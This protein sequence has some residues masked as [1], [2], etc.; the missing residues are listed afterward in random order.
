MQSVKQNLKELK[1]IPYRGKSRQ[2]KKKKQFKPPNIRN[3]IFRCVIRNF[4]GIS[5]HGRLFCSSRD[6]LQIHQVDCFSTSP[7]QDYKQLFD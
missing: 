1:V 2:V 4:Q 7:F 3:D 5:M 6:S